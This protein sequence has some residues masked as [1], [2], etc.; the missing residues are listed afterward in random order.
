MSKGTI[1]KRKDGR[2][3]ARISMGKDENGKR[4]WRTLLFV[5]D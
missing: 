1:Y 2:R 4:Q 5:R 3:E